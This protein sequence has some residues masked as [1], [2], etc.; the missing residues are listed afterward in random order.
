MTARKHPAATVIAALVTAGT[1][2]ATA[3]AD[4]AVP[5]KVGEVLTYDVS[6]STFV[7]A[8][9]ATLSVAGRRP[10]AGGGQ[11]YD[12]VGEGAPTAMLDKL[13]HVYYKAQTFLYTQTLQPSISTVYSDEKGRKKLQ[14]TKFVNGT[15]EYQPKADAEVERKTVPKIALDALSA[16]YVMRIVPLKA[17]QSLTMPLVDGGGLYNARWQASGPEPIKTALGT[18]QAW[19]ITPTVTDGTGK[20][21]SNRKM[22]IWMTS[23][24]RRLPVRL[25]V[26]LGVGSFTLTLSKVSG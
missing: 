5:F 20:T 15:I 18:L 26:A 6:W 3:P 4:V 23:D 16:V 9:T 19:R 8:G 14:T 25:E 2:R 1:T 21:I 7:T 22:T 10:L 13:Y 17:G 11:A 12:L 24:G